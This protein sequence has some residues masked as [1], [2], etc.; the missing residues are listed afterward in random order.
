[1]TTKSLLDSI[2]SKIKEEIFEKSQNFPLE[3][4][5][6]STSTSTFCEIDEEYDPRR[7]Y[8]YYSKDHTLVTTTRDAAKLVFNENQW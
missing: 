1:M 3:L 2:D 7:S 8:D 6:P 4:S 5:L